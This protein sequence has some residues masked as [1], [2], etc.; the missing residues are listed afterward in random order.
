M[1][2]EEKEGFLF[3]H[4]S[5]CGSLQIY[6]VKGESFCGNCGLAVLS[7][8]SMRLIRGDREEPNCSNCDK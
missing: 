7:E 2:E 1:I 5:H 4:C 3:P 8:N 6:E